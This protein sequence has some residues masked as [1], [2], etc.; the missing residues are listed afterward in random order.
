M[1]IQYQSGFAN[2]FESEALAGALPK[3][4]TSPQ[5]S[6]LGLYAEQLS[7]TSFTMPR[8]QNLRTWF[9]RIRPSVLHSPY[10]LIPMGSWRSGP[11][12]EMP[13]PPSQMRWDP[14]SAPTKQVD[15]IDGTTTLAGNGDVESH[16]GCAV[17]LYSFNQS[18]GNRYFCN[19]DGDMLF[20]PEKGTLKVLTE[21]GIVEAAPKELLVVP[22]GL[23]FK[24]EPLSNEEKFCRGYI[25][26]NYGA[27]FRLPDLGP[28]G[29][30]SLANPRHFLSPVAHFEDQE[31][32]FKLVT[33]FQGELWDC[34]LDHSPLDVVAWWGN[35]APYK[36][37]LD[38]FNTV[39]SI[40]F[41]HPDPSIFTVLTS[42][43]EIPG[44]ANV[45]FVIFPPRWM[46]AQNTF[47]PPY[48]HR[49]FMSE[50]MGLIV[51]A[52]DAKGEGFVPGGGSIHNSMSAH[53]PDAESFEKASGAE[54]KPEYYANTLAFMFES[55]LVFRPT[56]FAMTTPLLQK[57]YLDCWKGLKKN[58]EGS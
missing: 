8:H 14:L 25:C 5:K 34:E 47:R 41:D 37:D 7:G 24:V 56:P 35:Y 19:T 26:E 42:P 39:G 54:L 6:D 55:N 23:K 53:G 31:G 21:C 9:Y 11:F 46:V 40:S 22:R 58:F 45:D 10:R 1:K 17:H 2:H 57:N 28:I 15:F 13:V 44:Q 52:Y 38:L 18:M 48:Y 32:K 3:N 50:Y 43:S 29:A 16:K 33:K 4:Q 27:P 49:N 12:S 51:G 20:L 36:Y 30:N